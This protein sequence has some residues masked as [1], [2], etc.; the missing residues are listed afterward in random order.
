[1]KYDTSTLKINNKLLYWD[2]NG[3]SYTFKLAQAMFTL[4]MEDEKDAV[5]L[6]AAKM[7]SIIPATDADYDPV[8]DLADRLQMR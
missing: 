7:R 6:E 8:R 3:N 2:E 5:I 1:L 4:T